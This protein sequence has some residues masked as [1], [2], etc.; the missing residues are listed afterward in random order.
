MCGECAVATVTERGRFE[1]RSSLAT[2]INIETRKEL[3]LQNCT[4]DQGI[5]LPSECIQETV[6][7]KIHFLSERKHLQ[8]K[9]SSNFFSYSF[10][11][12]S[13]GRLSLSW[14]NMLAKE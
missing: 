7:C 12:K 8:R 13:A 6:L 4:C 11:A 14:E 5:S 1:L 10:L 3:Q 2:R 9:V